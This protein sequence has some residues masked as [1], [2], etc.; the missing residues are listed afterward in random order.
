MKVVKVLF[1]FLFMVFTSAQREKKFVK[2]V[3]EQ[4]HEAVGSRGCANLTLVLDNWKY[5][6]VT[7]VKDLLLND[8][9]TVLPDYGR[10]QP[11]S[12]ALGDLYK[13]FNALKDRLVD[14][15]SKFHSVEGF[16]DEMRKGRKA[17]PSP[18]GDPITLGQSEAVLPIA[19]PGYRRGRRTRVVVRRIQRPAG[20][21]EP[22]GV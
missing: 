17:P 10:I 18:R 7:Q 5:A 13:E 22:E 15:T 9:R 11:L 21:S 16:V 12:D 14:L 2:P 3:L 1:L 19:D 20:G 6:I 8:H 4:R